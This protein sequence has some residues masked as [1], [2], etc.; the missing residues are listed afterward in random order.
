MEKLEFGHKKNPP[1]PFGLRGLGDKS[2]LLL[3]LLG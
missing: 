2:Y 3:G 1:K